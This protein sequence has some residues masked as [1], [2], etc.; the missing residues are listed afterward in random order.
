M[1]DWAQ[2][3]RDTPAAEH[4]LHFNNAGSAVDASHVQAG[5]LLDFM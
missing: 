1:P 4:R 3:R 2:V 5:C